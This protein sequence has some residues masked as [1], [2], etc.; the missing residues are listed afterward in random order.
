MERKNLFK[1]NAERGVT[2]K[3]TQKI[4]TTLI[5]ILS[6]MTFVGLVIMINSDLREKYIWTTTLFLA[7]QFVSLL[8]YLVL[9]YELK[10]IWLMI[11]VMLLSGFLIEYTGVKTG[12][13]FGEYVYT[14]KLQ[15]QIL[16][17]PV[18]ISLSWVVVV[19]TSFLIVFPGSKTNLFS[20]IV[21]SSL[22]VLGLDLM[23]EPFAAFINSFWIW[24]SGFVPVQNYVSWLFIAAMFSLILGIS[25]RERD[26]KP[27][28]SKIIKYTPLIILAINLLQ[29]T[30]IN[31]M[32]AFYTSAI[33]GLVLISAIIYIKK[34]GTV[35]V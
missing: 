35:E 3:T 18:A 32:N 2:I 12:F 14:D 16:N 17:V 8:L 24:R 23:L 9:N 26:Y 31:F 4:L 25:L 5:V 27:E 7:L 34:R 15:P 11:P 21:Y 22:L 30:V 10:G 33:C 13:P 6:V 20:K 28:Y 19:V 29:F 1:N